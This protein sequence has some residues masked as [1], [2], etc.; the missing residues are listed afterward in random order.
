MNSEM[1][2][3]DRF[4]PYARPPNFSVI[5]SYFNPNRYRTKRTN[6]EIFRRS[7]ELAFRIPPGYIPH[8]SVLARPIRFASSKLIVA[9]SLY[10]LPP[11]LQQSSRSLIPQNPIR[12]SDDI[13]HLRQNLGFQLRVIADP[14][15][16]RGHTPDG[17]V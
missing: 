13:L 16:E 3:P 6:Y 2:L 7:M 5:T 14:G 10:L 4:Q 8:E 9:M 11:I 15:I 12:L 17:R 1:R